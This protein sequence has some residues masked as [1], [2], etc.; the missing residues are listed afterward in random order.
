MPDPTINKIPGNNVSTGNSPKNAQ[1]NR[2]EES[3]PKYTNGARTDG[4]TI[5]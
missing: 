4:A 2:K 3:I 1:P 5:R